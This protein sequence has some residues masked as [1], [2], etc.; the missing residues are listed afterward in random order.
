MA[1]KRTNG[2]GGARKITPP[3]GTGAKKVS[4]KPKTKVEDIEEDDDEEDEVEETKTTKKVTPAGKKKV[5]PP[6]SKKKVVE[7][8]D[9][10]DDDDIDEEEIE[11]DDDDDDEEDESEEE[12]D[13][14]D[15][16]D[17]DESDDDD[18]EDDSE[19]EDEDDDS[20]DEDDEDEEDDD[21][22]KPV[23]K[24]SKGKVSAKPSNKAKG[25][26]T[27][28]KNTKTAGKGKASSKTKGKA[29]SSGKV[30]S[31]V[32]INGKK[33]STSSEF[34][35]G[36]SYSKDQIIAYI[37]E[38]LPD[39][40]MKAGFLG[41][42]EGAVDGNGKEITRDMI[43]REITNNFADEIFKMIINMYN[44]AIDN[45]SKIVFAKSTFLTPKKQMGRISKPPIAHD[46]DGFYTP[47]KYKMSF[48]AVPEGMNTETYEVFKKKGK[49]NLYTYEDENG[50][51]VTIDADKI[52]EASEKWFEENPLTAEE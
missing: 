22:E 15:E 18:D 37:K 49:G 7:E 17:E 33:S 19:E 14:D 21:E 30:S 51:K 38:N 29:K 35:Y 45:C 41:L 6:K 50:K 48:N 28:A 11:E 12:D 31:M 13:D 34:V 40:I 46:G 8:E 26:S 52:I 27:P 24:N 4:V 20:E 32:S 47:P 9:E 2:N 25:K 39:V 43:E 1:I 10:D 44:E 42:K 36:K 16:E 23:K 5:T 3:K